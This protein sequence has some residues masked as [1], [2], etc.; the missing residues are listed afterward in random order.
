MNLTIEQEINIILQ[1]AKNLRGYTLE[2]LCQ[3]A[4]ILAPKH[5]TNAKGLSGQLIE[6]LL[7][8]EAQSRPLPDFP[9][10]NLEIKTIPINLKQQPLET[11]YVCTAHVLPTK[12]DYDFYASTLYRKIQHILWLPLIVPDPNH[13]SLAHRIVGNAFLWRPSPEQ[14]VAIKAD[15]QDLTQM[16]IFGQ[17]EQVTSHYGQV[18]QIRPKASNSKMTTESLNERGEKILT[19]PR[20]FYLRKTFTQEILLQN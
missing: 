7:G 11:T 18:L 9:R 19:L 2:Q 12:V 6:Y 5:M 20:G 17:A 3:A 14:L 10:L 4:G 1:K 16:L 15:W 8:A 13:D